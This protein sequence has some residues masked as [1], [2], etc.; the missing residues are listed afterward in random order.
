MAEFLKT[1]PVWFLIFLVVILG[2]YFIFSMKS[3][4]AGLQL[5]LVELK[6]LIKEL[7]EDRN[8]H[9]SRIVA[10]ETTCA[11]RTGETGV[12]RQGPGRRST[13]E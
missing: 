11:I 1:V 2:G 5:T 7:F 10:L 9:E 13:D 8:D 6:T 12:I 4:F 3:L